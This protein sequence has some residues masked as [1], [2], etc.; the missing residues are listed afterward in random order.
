MIREIWLTSEE[1]GDLGKS[2][3]PQ[4]VRFDQSH[5]RGDTKS[6]VGDCS[7]GEGWRAVAMSEAYVAGYRGGPRVRTRRERDEE[8]EKGKKRRRGRDISVGSRRSS[9]L[10]FLV[11][12][13]SSMDPDLPATGQSSAAR[14]STSTTRGA[15]HLVLLVLL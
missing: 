10:S 11:T 6:F 2:A 12:L 9:W 1:N 5:R 4:S 14:P 13:S 3:R 8:G 15:H 7:R